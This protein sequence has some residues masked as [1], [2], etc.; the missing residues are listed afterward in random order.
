MLDIFRTLLFLKMPNMLYFF[1]LNQINSGMDMQTKFNEY[2]LT[3]FDNKSNAKNFKNELIKK[4]NDLLN[5]P[6]KF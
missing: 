4:V 6:F 2:L 1:R 3:L 5:M